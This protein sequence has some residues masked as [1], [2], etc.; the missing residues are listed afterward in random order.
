MRVSQSE[1]RVKS[2]PESSSLK[3]ATCRLFA[4]CSLLVAMSSSPGNGDA[5]AGRLHEAFLGSKGLRLPSQPVKLNLVAD[6]TLQTSNAQPVT[7]NLPVRNHSRSLIE[8][9]FVR[10]CSSPGN[11]IAIR[12]R[13]N[14]LP[15]VTRSKLPTIGRPRNAAPDRLRTPNLL[16]CEYSRSPVVSR[17]AF[18]GQETSSK[19]LGM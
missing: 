13:A 10:D 17:T 16:D 14:Q 2:L 9:R 5:S 19:K 4:I 3:T 11:L 18:P 6:A 1:S 7:P 15:E 8:S 12:R